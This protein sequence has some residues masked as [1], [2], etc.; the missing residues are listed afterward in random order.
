MRSS[1][2][3]I[4]LGFGAPEE[5]MSGIYCASW[6]PQNFYKIIGGIPPRGAYM[7]HEVRKW[8]S[9]NEEIRRCKEIYPD[10]HRRIECIKKLLEKYGEDGMIYYAL[11]EEYESLGDHLEALRCYEKA[12]DLFPLPRW[13]EK[14]QRAILRVKMRLRKMSR[15]PE[16]LAKTLYVVACTKEKIWD[17]IP[18]APAFLPARLAYRG[19]HFREFLKFIERMEKSEDVRWLILSAKYG[20]IE[21]WHPISDYDIT[22]GQE[23]AITDDMLRRQVLHRLFWADKKPLSDFEEVLFYGPETYYEKVKKAFD[24]IAEVSRL[25]LPDEDPPDPYL[26]RVLRCLK[27]A[28]ERLTE[29]PT[30]SVLYSFNAVMFTLQRKVIEQKGV[31]ILE[32]LRRKGKLYME[33]LLGV[34]RDT[35]IDLGKDVKSQLDMLRELRNK[36]V[37]EGYRADEGEGLW[38]IGLAE[39]LAFSW[40][41]ELQDWL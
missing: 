14:A 38:A 19:R 29:D 22:F 35:G 34:L 21:P 12:R 37:H 16:G 2:I 15:P 41:P 39:G 36:I 8:I 33:V 5:R 20:F 27:K 11:G 3:N 17:E 40:Y 7:D 10:A 9:I 23:G 28:K 18:T 32:E 6:A 24:G 25:S 31:K 13:K 4:N 26:I 1:L 30:D